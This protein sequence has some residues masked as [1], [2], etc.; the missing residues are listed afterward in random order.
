MNWYWPYVVVRVYCMN[1]DCFVVVWA[2]SVH[3][4]SVKDQTASQAGK[5]RAPVDRTLLGNLLIMLLETFTHRYSWLYH[6]LLLLIFFLSLSSVDIWLLSDTVLLWS[7]SSFGAFVYVGNDGCMCCS[8]LNSITV[9]ISVGFFWFPSNTRSGMTLIYQ[10]LIP[11]KIIDL[12]RQM[13][14]PL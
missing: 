4:K 5:V 14:S 8:W 10:I 12:L 3:F 7:G 1:I 9:K 13:W 11:P 2:D 6:L